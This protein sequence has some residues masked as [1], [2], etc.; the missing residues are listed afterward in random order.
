M[1]FT[2]FFRHQLVLERVADH[3]VP[4]L[5]GRGRPRIWDAGAATGQE[6]NTLA[7]L[8][9]ERMG[10]FAFNNLRIDATDLDPAGDFAKVVE[11]GSYPRDEL[12]RLPGGILERY[13]E[14]DGAAGRF[15]AVERIRSRV[16][17]RRHDLLSFEEIG[18]GYSLVLCKNVL[19]HFQPQE[20]VE[21]LRMFYRALGPGGFFATENT[22]GMPAE[23]G[24]WFERVVSGCQLF[25]KREAGPCAS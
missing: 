9:A 11:S 1:A 22:Q 19:L 6:P 3:L 5:A 25:R 8:L 7:I 15:R 21:V 17:F 4:A 18:Q 2:F 13:F 16:V 23:A 24:P 14:P 12:V 10:R 20:R